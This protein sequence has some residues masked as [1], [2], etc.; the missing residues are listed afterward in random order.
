[1]LIIML[2]N[3][4]FWDSGLLS[5]GIGCKDSHCGTAHDG[6]VWHSYRAAVQNLHCERCKSHLKL[7][8]EMLTLEENTP[9]TPLRT[10]AGSWF[11]AWPCFSDWRDLE[12]F[13]IAW[14][15]EVILKIWG[16]EKMGI[17]GEFISIEVLGAIYWAFFLWKRGRER[18]SYN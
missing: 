6:T 14:D 4:F 11:P 15:G 18:E 12:I 1:M 17:W 9:T 16:G 10:E 2:W 8:S 3:L 13:R 7:G 5:S